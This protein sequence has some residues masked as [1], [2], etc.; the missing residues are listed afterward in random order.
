M[1]LIVV[2]HGATANNAQ[3]RYTGHSDV[4]LSP[5][6]LR[7]AEALAAVLAAEPF[8]LILSSDLV[9]A[10]QTVAG[11]AARNAAPLRLDAD[12]REMAMGAWEGRTRAE[13]VALEPE[14]WA[15]WRSHPDV[16]APPGGETLL[17]LRDRAARAIDRC[18]AEHPVGKVL[19]VT[20]GGLI[21]V[22]LCHL[23]GI[24]LTHRRQFR[25][26]NA[27]ITEL[28]VGPDRGER[29]HPSPRL[30]A[31]LLRLNDTSHL[32]GLEGSDG[33]EPIVS[34]LSP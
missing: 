15:R 2:R 33:T 13:A 12:L 7:Q 27:G 28:E 6:G 25:R 22:L 26:D 3:Q 23:L 31:I 32:K 5:L 11:S 34:K 30:R 14:A 29:G 24:D 16:S 21:G 9:R 18:Y 4:P 10:R 1:R 17:Q 20:H 8:D 19:W